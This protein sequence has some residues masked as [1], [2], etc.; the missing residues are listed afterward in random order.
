[1]MLQVIVFSMAIPTCL[2][3]A[4]SEAGIVLGGTHVLPGDHGSDQLLL[5]MEITANTCLLCIEI[6]ISISTCPLA[7]ALLRF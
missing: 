4:A 5:Y 1:M 3:S 7:L 2:E 6:I